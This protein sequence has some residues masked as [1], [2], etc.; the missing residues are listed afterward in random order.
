MTSIPDTSAWHVSEE[1]RFD[2]R[3]WAMLAL[4]S[5]VLLY[6]LALAIYIARLPTDGW[7]FQ[8]DLAQPDPGYVFTTYFGWE[9]TPLQSGDELI[10]IEG[11]PIDK[12]FEDAFALRPTR[13][14][15]W[16]A[17]GTVE[18][19]IRRNGRE[20]EL[21][22]PLTRLFPQGIWNYIT[23]QYAGPL[24]V[25]MAPIMVGIGFFVF[26]RRPQYLPAQLLLLFCWSLA[27]SQLEF[28]PVSVATVLDPI[29]LFLYQT[30]ILF[31]VW[32]LMILPVIT[33]LLLVFPVV[34]PVLRRYPILV[35]L[36]LYVP[37]QLGPWLVLGL[38]LGQP[39]KVIS[40][41]NVVQ[42]FQILAPFT[43]MVASVVHT[44]RTVR[45]PVLLAQMRWITF[46]VLFGLMGSVL[47]WLFIS[48]TG[49]SR[50]YYSL[51]TFLF[52]LL[53]ISLAI[54]IL[55]YRLFDIDFLIRRTLIYGIVTVLLALIFAGSV[56]ALQ[57][58]FRA[59]IGQTSDI[60]IAISTLSTAALALPLR[61][62]IQATID[63]AFYREKYDAQK[64]LEGFVADLQNK[65]DL[66]G[67]AAETRAVVQKTL[68]PAS[69]KVWMAARSNH[70]PPASAKPGGREEIGHIASNDPVLARFQQARGVVEVDKLRLNSPALE[71]MKAEGDVLAV[72]LIHQGELTGLIT[73]GSRLSDQGYSAD[74]TQ[75]LNSLARQAA[76][77]FRV[78]DLVRQQSQEAQKRAEIEQEL[79]IAS[80]IQ[81][82][83]LPEAHLS[84]EGWKVEALYQP[85]RAVGG[86]FYDFI[87]LPDGRISIIIGDV[88]DKGVPAAL[89][90][91][92][93]RTVLRE[94]TKLHDSPGEILS[95]T[96]D[97]LVG[98][99]PEKMFVTCFYAILDPAANRLSVANA[100]HNVPLWN[101]RDAVKEVRVR[102][103][104]L[105][106]MEG[107]TYEED[108]IRISPGETVLFYTDGL[109]EAHN[110]E[111]DMFGIP[112]LMDLFARHP[113]GPGLMP[114]L[115]EHL[116]TFSG[117]GWEQE[118]DVTMIILQALP[119]GVQVFP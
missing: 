80:S 6:S 21:A 92:V 114:Y 112:R 56:V 106:L 83:L 8:F 119:E 40:A 3:S 95:A 90:M 96:N 99:I 45:D 76:S 23:S 116:T 19:I 108:E 12:V 104:P 101:T 89:V 85:A 60:A 7:E 102:G 31:S 67:L 32:Q 62:R 88:T 27:G 65:P 15:N 29:A 98:D 53:P 63:R 111:N 13:P 86:D 69:V 117:Q 115:L 2:R 51:L 54:A 10:A 47:G 81:H 28:T 4:A 103:M 39:A 43:V 57:T 71:R 42:I 110:D 58:I 118:D 20:L 113:D 97:S 9:P 94:T 33:H 36:A 52:M 35:L 14:A 17:G 74:D 18:Y 87:H 78:A 70:G 5:A 24:F 11:K 37:L 100:G 73:L 25:L 84:L 64:T 75:L 34:K 16:Q 66:E 30:P 1:R 49:I 61:N 68:K 77:A 38:N 50:T 44:F 55:R 48:L 105:G 107:M 79:R 91:A 93:T 26:I 41:Y 82:T 22:V 109:V 46:G 59:F 72:P